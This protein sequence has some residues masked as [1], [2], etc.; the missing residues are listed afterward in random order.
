M[1]RLSLPSRWTRTLRQDAQ[2]GVVLGVQSVPDGLATGLLAGL[3]PLNGLY[4]YMVGTL[5]GAAVTSSAFMVV[6][7]TGAMAMVIA[8]VPGLRPGAGQAQAVA[9]LAV[10]TGAVMLLAGFLK[11]GSLLRFVSNAVLVGFMNAVGVNIVLGQV[12]NLTGYAADGDNRIVRTVNT[13]LSPAH[14]DWPSV[15]IGLSTIALIVVLERTRVGSMGLVVAVIATSGLAALLGWASVATLD[16][17]G[18]SLEGLPPLS[19]PSVALVPQ[20]L[21][22]AASLAFVGLVQGAGISAIYG[23]ADGQRADVSRDFVGQGAANVA[24]AV[25]GGM[26]VGGSASASAINAAAGARTRLAPMIAALVMALV[27]LLFGSTVGHLAMPALA[28]LLI[29]VGI[30]TI[31]P[32]DIESVWKAGLVQRAVMVVTFVLTMLVPLQYAV[33]VGVGV[34]VVLHVVQQSNQVMIRQRVPTEAG[35][36]IEIDPV[37]VVPA[38]QV[39]VLQPYGSLFFASA[40][41]F[42]AA[43]PRVDAGSRRSVVIV[44]LRGHVDLGTTFIDVLAR[45]AAQLDDAGSRLVIASVGTAVVRQLS[46]GGVID[47]VGP[48]GV[49]VGDERVGAAV[50]RAV[51]DAQEWIAADPRSA[52]G[53]GD[54]GGPSTPGGPASG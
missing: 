21:V 5:A 34:S 27:V 7:G 6:Q 36:V 47:I 11:L 52:R 23:T 49:V 25:A 13:F 1:R 20:L 29:L 39:V 53:P 18:V 9:T 12:A 10:L 4:G 37:P 8:D 38:G 17:L 15:V 33:L 31:K 54:P 42:E 35:H 41:V 14:V 50:A 43:L 3:S 32:G 40:P 30:R 45:Y 51:S 2:A 26:P 22:P 19:L 48:E 24:S 16:D 46:A 28:G 44:R